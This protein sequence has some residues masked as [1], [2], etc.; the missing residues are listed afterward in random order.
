[1][2]KKYNFSCVALGNFDGIHIGHDILIKKMIQIS[3][4]KEQDSIIITFRF[5]NKNLPKSIHNLQYINNFNSKLEMLKNYEVTDVVDIG[6]DDTISKYTPEE[7][8]KNILIDKFNVK[9]I[10]I[11]Y[12]FK[13]GHKASGDIKTLRRFEDKYGYKVKEI[14][15]VRYNGIAVSSTL[16]RKLIHEGKI[17]DAN[18]LLTKNY[19]ISIDDIIIDYNK[20]LAFV[21][22][23]SNIIIPKDG[24]YNIII[25]K[26][27]MKMSICKADEK[28]IFLFDKKLDKNI[29]NKSIVF[30][31]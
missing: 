24:V 12:N 1:M 25:E 6:L 27:E 2:D 20:N 9:N 11:G 29:K 5:I 16:I 15:P 28:T 26:D 17:K 30:I 21:N 13:F 3:R 19:S 18:N 23:K 22:N 4:E 31:S 10:V 7:F 8:I 14:E